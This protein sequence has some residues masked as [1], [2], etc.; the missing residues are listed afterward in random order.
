MI[1]Q[2]ILS[3]ADYAILPM[4]HCVHGDTGRTLRASF[5][6]YTLLQGDSATLYIERP[7]GTFFEISGTVNVGEKYVDVD[8]TQALT[9]AGTVKCNL[10]ITSSGLTVQTYRLDIVCHPSHSGEPTTPEQAITMAALE[11]ASHLYRHAIKIE[12]HNTEALQDGMMF[13]TLYTKDSAELNTFQLLSAAIGSDKI[14]CT[15]FMQNAGMYDIELMIDVYFDNGQILFNSVAYG[16]DWHPNIFNPDMEYIT[17]T[18]SV[19]EMR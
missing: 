15:G 1:Q 12:Y 11:A 4:I 8:L 14:S 6:D 19:T 3:V 7:N 16:Y 10:C 17:I 2:V 18:D 9:T 5:K 13:L